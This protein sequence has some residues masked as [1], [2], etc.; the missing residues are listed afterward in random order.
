M[1]REGHHII[2][3]LEKQHGGGLMA[4]FYIMFVLVILVRF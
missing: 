2:E 1:V 3:H 4:E